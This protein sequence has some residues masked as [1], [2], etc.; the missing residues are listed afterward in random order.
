MNTFLNWS[1]PGKFLLSSVD[2]ENSSSALSCFLSS[3]VGI[4]TIT[5]HNR[6]PLPL[7]L[8]WLAPLPFILKIF[9]VWVYGGILSEIFFSKEE[10]KAEKAEESEKGE[11]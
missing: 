5:L 9:P 3:V 4:S 7:D 11:T 10:P 1:V 6:S 2:F 8:M